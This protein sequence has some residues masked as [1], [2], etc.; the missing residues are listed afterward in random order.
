MI[1]QYPYFSH[2]QEL[3]TLFVLENT[4][5]KVSILD[6]GAT[7]TSIIYKPLNRET[8]LGLSDFEDYRK[9]KFYL[10]ALVGR[11]ANRIN[12]GRFTLNDVTYQCTMNGPHSLHGGIVGFDQAHFK[13]EI[14]GDSLI[15]THLSK[16]GDHPTHLLQPQ[17]GSVSTDPQSSAQTQQ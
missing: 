1:K 13:S 4:F 12:S 2:N 14:K 16:D 15:L 7:L 8:T 17:C 3:I 6:Y 11:V 10:G 9:Q 5:L